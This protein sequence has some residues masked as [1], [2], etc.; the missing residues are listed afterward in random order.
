MPTDEITLTGWKRRITAYCAELG[1]NKTPRQVKNLASKIHL[2]AERM[3]NF[4]PDDLLR[5]VLDY[6]DPTGETAVA[7]VMDPRPVA[8]TY[9]PTDVTDWSHDDLE[10]MYL[11]DELTQDLYAA[12][13]AAWE[14]RNG[15]AA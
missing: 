4:D 1:I 5:S 12:D 11:E 8:P 13:L 9:R 10:R 6:S 15:A 2:R 14:E 3:Q 7:N